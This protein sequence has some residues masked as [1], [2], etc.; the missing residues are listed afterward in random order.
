MSDWTMV[1]GHCFE[2]L[3]MLGRCWLGDVQ[4]IGLVK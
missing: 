4:D 1:G 3:S 2:V